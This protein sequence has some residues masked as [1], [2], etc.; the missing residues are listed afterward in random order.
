MKDQTH[1]IMYIPVDPFNRVET[2][3]RCLDCFDGD[4]NH[5]LCEEVIKNNECYKDKKTP[6]L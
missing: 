1:C 5:P 6:V 2:T 4:G 3:G